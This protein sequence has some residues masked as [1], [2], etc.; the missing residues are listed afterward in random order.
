MV[1][2]GIIGLGFMGTAHFGHYTNNP[3]VRIVALCDKIEARR[4]GD[5]SGVGGNLAAAGGS[6]VDLSQVAGYADPAGL[7]ADANVDLV[8]ICLPTDLH[9][10]YAVAAL[11]AGKHVINEKPMALTA[12]DC[13]RIVAT[14][15]RARGYYMVAQCIRF[16]PVYALAKQIVDSGRLGK[17]RQIYL[18]RVA[19]TPRYSTENWLLD[20][21]RSGGAIFDLHVHDTDYAN[22]LAGVP[23]AVSAVGVKG[24]SGGWDD[25]TA[26]L[27]YPKGVVATVR[28]TWS[29]PNKWPFEMV[30]TL[31]CEKGTVHWRMTSGKPLQVITNDGIETPA[32]PDGDGWGEELKYFVGCIESKKRPRIV[33]AKTSRDSI[34]VVLAEAK[35][36]AARGK[37]V[38][39]TR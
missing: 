11:K 27:T 4:K 16:W 37:V 39:L 15:A 8:D 6:G 25:I 29:Y 32:V 33:T 10:T 1:R 22:Y 13:N 35:S 28:G 34:R 36:A 14:A 3:S 7:I 19:G 24:E 9:A 38:K 31:R 20:A 23:A 17:L 5:F 2:V 30:F 21:K 12:V 26:N 18:E